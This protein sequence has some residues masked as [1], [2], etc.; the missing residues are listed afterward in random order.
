MMARLSKRQ[1]A[2]LDAK[3]A[4][5]AE[6][7]PAGQDG[8]PLATLGPAVEDDD[9]AG[10]DVSLSQALAP[11]KKRKV[12]TETAPL[13]KGEKRMTDEQCEK[14]GADALKKELAMRGLRNSDKKLPNKKRLLKHQDR[15]FGTKIED[16]PVGKV[17]KLLLDS[18]TA[19]ED[20]DVFNLWYDTA[21]AEAVVDVAGDDA[22]D[23]DAPDAPDTVNVSLLMRAARD[24]FNLPVD[25]PPPGGKRRSVAKKS[26]AARDA[27]GE[28]A[29]L[30]TLSTDWEEWKSLRLFVVLFSL[31]NEGTLVKIM[32]GC[33]RAE[34]EEQKAWD[35]FAGQ[36]NNA[37]VVID[38]PVNGIDCNLEEDLEHT[39]KELSGKWSALKTCFAKFK[40]EMEK[41]G[42]QGDDVLLEKASKV[43]QFMWESYDKNAAFVAAIARDLPP[44]ASREA[45]SGR[46]GGPPVKG[47][48]RTA[49]FTVLADAITT[50]GG[51]PETAKAVQKATILEK[52]GTN[53]DKVED[54]SFKQRWEKKMND[55]LDSV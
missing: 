21:R 49:G 41:S 17:K 3:E 36:F 31:D 29:A 22:S 50:L 13:M 7:E 1:R 5:A 2:I 20:N 27:A 10:D 26:G 4:A 45:G 46:G 38:K 23:N 37:A 43:E 32:R 9:D 28:A 39:G 30:E 35:E 11:Q 24:H 42:N 52:I 6:A 16:E 19:L 34:L 47:D 8:Q 54:E 53:V 44:H 55:L 40:L 12:G 33:E 25:R 18:L 51:D 15:H 14:L 48:P